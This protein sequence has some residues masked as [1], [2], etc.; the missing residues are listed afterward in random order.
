MDDGSMAS[1]LLATARKHALAVNEIQKY[2]RRLLSRS[3][4]Y[5]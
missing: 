4:G 5:E 1:Q 2:S 3:S